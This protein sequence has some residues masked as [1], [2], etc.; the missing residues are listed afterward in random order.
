[1]VFQTALRAKCVVTRRDAKKDGETYVMV[2]APTKDKARAPNGVKEAVLNLL[3]LDHPNLVRVYEAYEHKGYCYYIMNDWTSNIVETS[4]FGITTLSEAQ[5]AESIQELAMALLY[6]HQN[7]VVHGN[8]CFDDLHFTREFDDSKSVDSL[9]VLIIDLGIGR[10]VDEKRYVELHQDRRYGNPP[11][12][13]EGKFTAKSDVWTLGSVA[14]RLLT[15]DV[16]SEHLLDRNQATFSVEKNLM[17]VSEEARDFCLKCLKTD[18]AERISMKDAAEHP[19]FSHVNHRSSCLL[20]TSVLNSLNKEQ[21]RNEFMRR[22]C[23]VSQTS[24]I[25]LSE[26]QILLSSLLTFFCAFCR[27]YIHRLLP[28]IWM[29]TN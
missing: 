14:F 15:G 21:N 13:K 5:V 17:S 7:G 27:Y 23:T 24:L 22:A 19:W 9:N 18:A 6:M 8:L 12:T 26:N 28:N 3:E 10:H 11:E 2:I 16:S 29:T 1:M 20:S 25:G 4:R